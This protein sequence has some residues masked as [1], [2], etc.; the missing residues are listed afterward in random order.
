MAS[1]PQLIAV[2]GPTACGK[3]DLAIYLAQLV[4]GEIVSVDSA[5]LYKGLD[6]GT[7][8]PSRQSLRQIPHHLIDVL[9][10]WEQSSAGWFRQEACTCIEEIAA[11]GKPVI[12]V[13]G[14]SLYYFAVTTELPL[15]PPGRA[16]RAKLEERIACEGIQGLID[17]LSCKAPEVLARIDKKNP[18][19]VVRALE[20]VEMRRLCGE[21]EDGWYRGIEHY[22]QRGINLV[23]IG[24]SMPKEAHRLSIRKRAERMLEEGLVE[25]VRQVFFEATRPPAPSVA[26][27]VGYKQVYECLNAGA[28]RDRMVEAVTAATWKLAR[29]Q[30]AWFRRDPRLCWFSSEHPAKH[31]EAIG[32]FVLRRLEKGSI[33]SPPYDLISTPIV[34]RASA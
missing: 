32:M 26:S 18:R 16:L 3:S 7:A 20:V 10:P 24:L 2:V 29:R 13:G 23:G 19:R 31:F 12:L 25:E 21:S 14:S 22:C 6:I 17:E 30:R 9:D 4:G 5:Q 11:K 15:F 1:E 8:K 34:D 27:A 33:S 28:G